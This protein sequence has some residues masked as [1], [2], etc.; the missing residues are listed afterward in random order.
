MLIVSNSEKAS[1]DIS[2]LRALTMKLEAKGIDMINKVSIQRSLM[3]H[4]LTAVQASLIT[5]PL[6]FIFLKPLC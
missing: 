3:Y 5:E 1:K 4:M 2:P 6:C